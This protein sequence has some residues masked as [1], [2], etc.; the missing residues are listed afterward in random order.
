MAY[1]CQYT[2]SVRYCNK[3]K[4]TIRQ[5]RNWYQLIKQILKN[6]ES[7]GRLEK[8]AIELGDYEINFSPRHAVKEYEALLSGLRIATEMGRKHLRA[9]V[10]FKIVAQQVNG[11]FKA[12]DI[13]M[14]QYL[15]IIEKFS[16]NFETLEVVQITRN[17]N[18]K[19][20]VL[21]K[22]ATLTFD[23]LHKKVLVEVLKDKSTDEKGETLPT[24]VTEARR[25][26]VSAPLY[27]L[28][29]GVLYRKSYSGPNLRCLTPHQAIDVI[30]EMHEGLCAQHSGYTTVV[31][32]IMRQGYYWQTIYRDTA[33]VI[34]TCDACQWHGIVQRLPKYDLISVSSAWTFCKWAIDIVR[35]FLRSV[36]NAKF[37]VVA[38]DFFSKWVE[39]KVLAR[40]TGE[41]IKTFVWNDIIFRYG[42]LNEIVSDN[43]KQF[44]DNPFRSWCEELN[45]KQTFTSVVHPQANCQVNVTNKEIVA[46]IK[47]RL[48]SNSSVLCENLN[49]L[50]ER[51]IMAA[52]R[53][54]DAKQKMAKYYNKRVRY[55]QFKEGD[56]VLRDNEASRQEKQ[57][58]LGPCWESPYK[59][60]NAHPK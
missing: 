25:I 53:Q 57:G 47:A 33:K 9:Y 45:I 31:G 15:Q 43:G 14:K 56:L 55:V 59:I 34:K 1:K 20:D 19:A 41:N 49:L 48:E 46:D 42:L 50:K 27:V 36:G 4:L 6:P 7:S 11:A 2:S 30:R 22:L 3:V 18:K 10:D 32:R 17:K 13:S 29:N 37:L 60:I 39:A 54:T 16:K 28:E 40:I 26:K 5:L 8:W 23:H 35:P 58:K 24:D 52:I 21:S 12:K 51:R 44:A 38:I